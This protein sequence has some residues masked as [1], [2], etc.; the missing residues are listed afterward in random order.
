VLA[1]LLSGL[2]RKAEFVAEGLQDGGGQYIP[3]EAVARHAVLRSPPN[4]GVA[5]CC[6]LLGA[7]QGHASFE[8]EP[9]A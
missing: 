8:D 5:H 7:L 1:Q 3:L 9:G 6:D 2:A 4:V